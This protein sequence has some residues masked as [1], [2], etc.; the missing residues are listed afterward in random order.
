MSKL[1]IGG[2]GNFLIFVFLLKDLLFNSAFFILS[3]KQNTQ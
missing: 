1:L 3:F 2:L